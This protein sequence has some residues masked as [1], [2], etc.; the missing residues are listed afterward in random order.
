MDFETYLLE[1]IQMHPALQP[2][3]IWKLC[4]Q[5]AFGPEHL[6]NDLQGA[7]EYLEKEYETTAEQDVPLY[8]PIS[9]EI[10]RVNLAAWKFHGLPLEWLFRLFTASCGKRED[11]EALFWA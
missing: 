11:G 10:C 4:Y 3:D 2:Q 7:R 1:Q 6:L 8:E 9:N 5:A